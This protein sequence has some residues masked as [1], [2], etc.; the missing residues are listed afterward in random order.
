MRRHPSSST[1]THTWQPPS[2]YP[3]QSSSHTHQ[4]DGVASP[5]ELSEV[6]AS[7]P[8]S[9]AC[10]R[11]SARTASLPTSPAQQHTG[12]LPPVR[13][14]WI[15]PPN[16]AHTYLPSPS[17]AVRRSG[18][19]VRT[20]RSGRRR[21]CGRAAG[22]HQHRA[23][24]RF[25]R[26]R[27][28]HQARPSDV[29]SAPPPG[30]RHPVS[31]PRPR[32]RHRHRDCLLAQHWMSQHSSMHSVHWR[33]R[34]HSTALQRQLRLHAGSRAAAAAAVA[35]AAACRL[36]AAAPAKGTAPNA[37]RTWRPVMLHYSTMAM[38]VLT[39]PLQCNYPSNVHPSMVPTRSGN[40][41]M[42]CCCTR[43]CH[44]Q[45]C[46]QQTTACPPTLLVLRHSY[47]Q[48]AWLQ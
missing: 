48:H 13:H 9:C 41:R 30:Q 42:V 2:S 24:G 26:G 28:A 10:A 23:G 33:Q 6:L 37:L 27:G 39:T 43:A 25:R 22:R 16:Q 47:R 32:C 17:G 20:R 34:Q 31:T 19:A 4:P 29:G 15:T 44:L 12:H 5:V 40:A 45:R 3:S 36:L 46:S 35:A 21:R 14:G 11:T 1:Q 38:A 18:A 8:H 7:V